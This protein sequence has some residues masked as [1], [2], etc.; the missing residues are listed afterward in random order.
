MKMNSR[1]DFSKV[2]MKWDWEII[3]K[4]YGGIGSLL[5]FKSSSQI[6]DSLFRNK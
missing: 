4:F 2:N 3:V 1:T 5:K 6:S